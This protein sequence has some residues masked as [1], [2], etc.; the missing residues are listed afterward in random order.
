MLSTARRT[1]TFLWWRPHSRCYFQNI[2]LSAVRKAARQRSGQRERVM[3]SRGNASGAGLGD[4]A[5]PQNTKSGR[6][7]E[8]QPL[9][10]CWRL[11]AATAFCSVAAAAFISYSSNDGTMI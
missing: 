3:E 8:T 5:S 6:A 7:V 2:I 10:L 1:V 4:G 11:Q 9:R